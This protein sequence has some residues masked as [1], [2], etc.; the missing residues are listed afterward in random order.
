MTEAAFF[1]IGLYRSI[2]LRKYRLYTYTDTKANT[3]QTPKA[4]QFFIWT[5]DD[6]TCY[7]NE[8]EKFLSNS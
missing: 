6:L 8:N 7:N 1:T 5:Q 3:F 4:V 2:G